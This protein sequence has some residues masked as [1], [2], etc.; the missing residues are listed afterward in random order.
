V[1]GAGRQISLESLIEGKPREFKTRTFRARREKW[2]TRE[3]KGRAIR[4][5]Y[6]SGAVAGAE[7]VI[8]SAVYFTTI[9]YGSRMPDFT[10]R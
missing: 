6:F 1:R 5:T 2:A 7:D 4:E 8:Q 10:S 3:F 9:I